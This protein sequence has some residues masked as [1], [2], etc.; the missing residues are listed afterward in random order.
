MRPECRQTRDTIEGVAGWFWNMSS[1]PT[2]DDADYE[3]E[4]EQLGA[5]LDA[6]TQAYVDGPAE[7][8]LRVLDDDQFD[9]DQCEFSIHIRPNINIS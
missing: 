1:L 4:T 2:I 3:N 6:A 9:C 7:C 5:Q 8:T